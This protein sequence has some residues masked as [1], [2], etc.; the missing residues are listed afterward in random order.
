[1]MTDKVSQAHRDAR[2]LTSTGQSRLRALM[3]Q[4]FDPQTEIFD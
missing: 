3:L 4:R 2:S 1:M